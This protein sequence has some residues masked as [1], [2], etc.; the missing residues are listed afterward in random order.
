M[1]YIH[2]DRTYIYGSIASQTGYPI[3]MLV[4]GILSLVGAIISHVYIGA[5]DIGERPSV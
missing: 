3:I 4:C 1:T 5:I 2:F